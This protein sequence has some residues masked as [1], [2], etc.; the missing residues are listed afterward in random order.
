MK[1]PATRRREVSGEKRAQHMRVNDCTI[2]SSYGAQ[3]PVRHGLR[4][5]SC[6]RKETGSTEPLALLSSVTSMHG[7]RNHN[8]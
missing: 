3:H 4:A 7:D 5:D 1:M 6:V 8:A 2:V